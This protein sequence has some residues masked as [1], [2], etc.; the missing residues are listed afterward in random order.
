MRCIGPD[1]VRAHGDDLR[2]DDRDAIRVGDFNADFT[3]ATTVRMF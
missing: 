1:L 2:G 3:P